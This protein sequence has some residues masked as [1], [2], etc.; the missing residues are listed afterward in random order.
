VVV[1]PRQPRVG[2]PRADRTQPPAIVRVFPGRVA[3]RAEG[4]GRSARVT[5][6][7]QDAELEAVLRELSRATGLSFSAA[8]NARDR[9]VT[10]KVEGIPV[11]DLVESL[12]RLYRLRGE[13][14][15]DRYTFRTR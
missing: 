15:G 13:R 2:A 14:E 12:E 9:R 7:A 4:R 10:L 3:V 11:D 5:L 8:E 6:E 1:P